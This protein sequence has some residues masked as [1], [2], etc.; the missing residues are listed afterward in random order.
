MRVRGPPIS[1]RN[2]A[3]LQKRPKHSRRVEL[4]GCSHRAGPFTAIERWRRGTHWPR[5]NGPLPHR[6]QH[7][8]TRIEVE[9]FKTRIGDGKPIVYGMRDGVPKR[10]TATFTDML[11]DL[12]RR[13]PGL[14]KEA[15]EDIARKSGFRRS[16]IRDFIDNG[17]V[18]GQLK[19]EKRKLVLRPKDATGPPKVSLPLDGGEEPMLSFVA[20]PAE[21]SWPHL[22]QMPA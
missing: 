21:P 3:Q 22:D 6:H 15:F 13:Q 12:V 20:V 5:R 17:I 7:K 14:S 4:T 2:R 19:Y 8:L 18:S 1:R 11:F 16:T 9:T 10:E